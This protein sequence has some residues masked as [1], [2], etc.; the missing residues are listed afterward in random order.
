MLNIRFIA[1]NQNDLSKGL[2]HSSPLDFDECALFSFGYT[3]DHSFW[4]KNVSFPISLIFLD[5]NFQV[6]HIGELLAEQEKA[7]RSGYPLI[8]Y[9]LEGHKNLP[10]E[11]DIQIGDF[12]LLADNKIKIVKGNRNAKKEL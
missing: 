11:Y 5:D 1:K 3:G 7:C 10:K 6:K 12:C 2:M 9:V 4:N 8:K